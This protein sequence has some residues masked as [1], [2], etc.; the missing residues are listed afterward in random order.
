M[1]TLKNSII[2]PKTYT[3][4]TPETAREYL[5]RAQGDYLDRTHGVTFQVVRLVGRTPDQYA[6]AGINVDGDVAARVLW[7]DGWLGLSGETDLG[8]SLAEARP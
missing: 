8:L 1:L 6:L 4:T 7:L 2:P 3:A 5:T